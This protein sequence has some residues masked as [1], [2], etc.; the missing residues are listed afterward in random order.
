MQS[1]TRLLAAIK[2]DVVDNAHAHSTSATNE[3]QRGTRPMIVAVAA[4]AIAVADIVDATNMVV[5]NTHTRNT[6]ATGTCS[7][8]AV[9]VATAATAGAVARDV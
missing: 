5:S 2:I 6:S 8:A 7:A 9:T 3:W 1:I 4:S